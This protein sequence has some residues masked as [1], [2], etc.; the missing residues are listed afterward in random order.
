LLEKNKKIAGQQWCCSS[1]EKNKKKTAG[2]QWCCSSLEK[3]RRR[4]LDNSGVVARWK[5]IRKLLDN[6]GDVT[7]R[8]II[9]T[10][11]DNVGNIARCTDVYKSFTELSERLLRPFTMLIQCLVYVSNNMLMWPVPAGR[12]LVRRRNREY[13]I[14][15]RSP[16]DKR[17]LLRLKVN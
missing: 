15:F 7:G 2:Q 11:L 17:S 3:I 5:R 8:K 1:L 12:P 14:L 13:Q 9:R 16:E 4:L 10:L 6:G